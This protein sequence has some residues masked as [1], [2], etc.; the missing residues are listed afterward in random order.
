MKTYLKTLK[1][2]SREK[3][4][5]SIVIVACFA[6]SCLIIIEPFFFREIIDSLFNFQGEENF[7]RGI[8]SIFLMWGAIVIS[9][10]CIQVFSAYSSSILANK[11]Y[12]DLWG[13]TFNK[14]LGF[15][16]N[17]F[18][19]KK[20]GTIVR[21]FERGLDNIYS[22]QLRF[23]SNIL[24]NFFIILI[25][26][27][28]IFYLNFKMAL[29]IIGS[30]PL[31]IFFSA[32]GINKTTKT[33]K[34]SDEKWS[35]LS[36][37][38]YDS[39]SNIFLVKSFTL[40]DKIIE[41][42]SQKREYA[43]IKQKEAIRWWGFIN[44]VTRSVGFILSILVFLSGSY[45]F[46]KN[47]ISLGTIVMF[48]GFSN[49]LI[50]IF[51][52]MF[53]NIIEYLW[54]KEK[55]NAF[56]EIWEQKPKI[57]D[58]DNAIKVGRLKGDIEF[59]NVSF[60]YGDKEDA[61]NNISFKINSGEMIAFVGHTGS[62]KTTTANLISR[63]YETKK[64]KILVDGLDIK[65]INIESLR[66]NIAIVFQE[67]TFF[68]ASL[69][70]N[71]KIDNEQEITEEGIE[72]SL[73]KARISH[74]LDRSKEGINQ[75]IGERGS[76]L[77]GGEKQRLSIARAILKDAPILV[78]DEAT[79][80][81]DAKTENEIQL[82]ISNLIKDKTTIVIAHRLSTIKKADRIFVFENGKIIE[83]GT[84]N[85]LMKEKGKFYELA[86]YQIAI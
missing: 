29:I 10:V 5:A 67:N 51:N 72:E 84:F 74:I 45:L 50:S 75:V 57:V 31:L 63:F 79:S 71:L 83:T 36:G 7:L 52:S 85:S 54:Q 55:I 49:I 86:S 66:K 48:L 15:S 41:K 11:I 47:E 65:K 4:L 53:W 14:I 78:L 43:Y 37:I 20:V 18:K 12:Y 21:N 28:V 2:I 40:R 33:Q 24:V 70:D 6:L 17:F 3:K 1:L 68:N 73:R 38:A 59:K 26:I 35:E 76:K 16:I 23:F 56:F 44:G 8:M 9:N 13:K 22:L 69:L 60:S 46:T 81:L 39:I 64:G 30:L 42:I 19:D 62:G 32:L 77:S 27:P 58:K 82:A 61:L 80:A 25:L 34:I